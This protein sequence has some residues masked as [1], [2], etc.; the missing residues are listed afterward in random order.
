MLHALRSRLAESMI[1]TIISITVIALASAA[2]LSMLRT[3]LIGNSVIGEKLQA[4][5]LAMEGLDAVQNIR[6]TNYLLFPDDTDTCWDKLGL[7]ATS[8]C[9]SATEI[10]DTDYYLLQ[11]FDS[12][13]KYRWDLYPVA[14][15]PAKPGYM[16]LFDFTPDATIPDETVPYYSDWHNAATADFT[17]NTEHAFERVI[18]V[19]RSPTDSTGTD[20]CAD[21]NCYLATA[22]VTWTVN[23]LTQSISLSRLIVNVY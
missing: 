15:S 3:S 5:E 21:G 10:S 12:D 19:D 20:L 22:T 17:T 4:I 11:T 6:D 13:P 9:S 8:T 2:A 1:E 18:T 7:T 23:N 14:W 16:N